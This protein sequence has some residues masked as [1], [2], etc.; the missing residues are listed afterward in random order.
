MLKTQLITPRMVFT[1]VMF[2]ALFLAFT[3]SESGNVTISMALRTLPFIAIALLAVGYAGSD[4]V[5]RP[6]ALASVCSLGALLLLKNIEAVTPYVFLCVAIYCASYAFAQAILSSAELRTVVENALAALIAVWVLLLTLQVGGYYVTGSTV[7]FHELL[8][9]AS[10]QR[11]DEALGLLRFGGVH[12]EPG[13]YANWMYGVVVARALLIRRIHT[14]LHTAAVLSTLMTLSF[15]GYIAA[16]FYLL[17]ALLDSLVRASLRGLLSAGVTTCIC[18]V[19]FIALEDMVLPYLQMRADLD[20]IHGA[21][22]ISVLQ[23]MA[24]SMESWLL[25]GSPFINTPCYNCTSVQDSGIFV[26]AVFYFGLAFV[27][28]SL[29]VLWRAFRMFGVSGVVFVFPIFIGKYFY[30]DPIVVFMF[31]LILTDRRPKRRVSRKPV[32]VAARPV[33]ACAPRDA[34]HATASWRQ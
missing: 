16:A 17:S 14:P 5:V 13:T 30:W 2:V 15:W 25:F 22:S 21:S 24:G 3:P 23:G 7:T 33:A 10:E 8:F 34:R 26:N 27:A 28:L 29:Y 20:R 32:A 31:A 9:S 1:A 18:I 19:A 4:F 11:I 12:N 6:L